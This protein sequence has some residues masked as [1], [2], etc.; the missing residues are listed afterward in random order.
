MSAKQTIFE[1]DFKSILSNYD[2]GTYLGFKTFAKGAGQT[3][4][5][6]ITSTGKFV[7]RYYENRPESH[8][9]F[10]VNLFNYLKSKRYPVPTIIKD[11][12]NKSLG[13]HKNKPYIIIEY[14]EGEHCANPNSFFDKQALA[15]VIKI[16]AALHN[17]TCDYEPEYFKDRVVYD[18]EYCWREYKKLPK[19]KLNQNNELWLKSELDKLEFPETLP[20]GICHADLNYGNFLFKDG[21]VVAVLDFD[22]SF[23][24]YLVYDI[25][26][27]IYWWAG[28]LESGF[29]TE[30]AMFI[31]REY[32]KWRTLGKAEQIHIY[33]ALKLI[34]LLGIAWSE[35]VDNEIEASKNYLKSVS[36]IEREHFLFA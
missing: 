7:L 17:L 11:M 29:N 27:L 35:D 12:H 16:V 14:V 21:R 19:K 34:T 22:M 32:S 10:E 5:L 25:A 28:K 15:E 33:D 30:K 1:E 6:L 3:T 2:L 4:I 9:E 24:S 26:S 31:I 23:Y 8:V 18:A 36:S 20:K 13:I